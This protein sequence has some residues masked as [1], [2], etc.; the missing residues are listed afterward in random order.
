MIRYGLPISLV[1]WSGIAWA[2]R[3]A[4]VLAALIAWPFVVRYGWQFLESKIFSK[5]GT[6]A[7]TAPGTF[8]ERISDRQAFEHLRRAR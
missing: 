1:L 6:D 2:P 3:A 5:P 8:S 4:A 7:K